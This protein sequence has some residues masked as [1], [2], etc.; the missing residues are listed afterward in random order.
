MGTPYVNKPSDIHSLLSFLQVQ[1]LCKK[2]V[3][4]RLVVYPIKDRREIGLQTIRTT[5]AHIMLRR[6]KGKVDLDLPAKSVE[7]FRVRF[8]PISEHKKTY[9]RLFGAARSYVLN[10]LQEGKGQVMMEITELFE[11]VLRIRQLCCHGGLMGQRELDDI[12]AGLEHNSVQKG[13]SKKDGKKVLGVLAGAFHGASLVE[14]AV[15]CSDMQEEPAAVLRGCKHLF[16]RPCLSNVTTCLCPVCGMEFGP[17][18][19][20]DKQL[21]H[22]ATKKTPLSLRDSM[23]Y[24]RS[25]KVQALLDAIRTMKP[26]EKGVMFSQW[27]SFLNIVEYELIKEGHTCTRIDGTMSAQERTDAMT[28]FETDG[29]D[30]MKTPRF[31]LCSLHAC[32]AG[33]NLTRGN[34]AFMLDPC[35]RKSS[36]GP[37]SS[38]WTD[39]SRPLYPIFDAG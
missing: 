25:P 10:L 11:L 4:A 3:F 13:L 19:V 31:I 23:Q 8:P 16:C 21:A 34:V 32:G 24:G 2:S 18:G 12:L 29:C 22:N 7:M 9:D 35:C 30:S 14:C 38:Y 28:K 36:Y 1:P 6:T 15:C 26:D 5:M 27:T 33:I 20:V 17:D 39:S 37:H